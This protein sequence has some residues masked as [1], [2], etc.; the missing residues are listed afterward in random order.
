MISRI[1]MA[2][3][4]QA[5]AVPIDTYAVLAEVMGTWNRADAMEFADIMTDHIVAPYRA[6][7][8]NYDKAQGVQKHGRET[9][10]EMLESAARA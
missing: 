2:R 9:K 10:L 6:L 8:E 3:V 7:I 1:S 4:T 5:G